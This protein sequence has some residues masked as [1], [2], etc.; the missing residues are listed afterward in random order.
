VEADADVEMR[1]WCSYAFTANGEG[2]FG[3][4]PDTCPEGF[5]DGGVTEDTKNC[6]QPPLWARNGNPGTRRLLIAPIS[7]DDPRTK[8]YGYFKTRKCIRQ[9]KVKVFKIS[10]PTGGCPTWPMQEWQTSFETCQHCGEDGRGLTGDGRNADSC[11]LPYSKNADGNCFA[12]DHNAIGWWKEAGDSQFEVAKGGDEQLMAP[13]RP[14]SG[15][16]ASSR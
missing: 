14:R 9:T 2:K 15:N 11:W 10:S 7:C 16:G 8:P 5:T 13:W 6:C 4:E 12:Y 1:G 3:S